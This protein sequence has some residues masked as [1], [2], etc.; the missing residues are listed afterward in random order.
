MTDENIPVKLKLKPF[1]KRMWF[2]FSYWRKTL[3]F[4]HSLKMAYKIEKGL[5]K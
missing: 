5:R 4:W 2:T 1:H 3:G